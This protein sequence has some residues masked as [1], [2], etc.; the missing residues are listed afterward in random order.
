[1]SSV[2]DELLC[3]VQAAGIHIEVDPPD[4]IVTPEDLLTPELEERLRQH[5]SEILRRLELE[6]SRNRLESAGICVAVWDDGSMRVVV[7]E[8]ETVQ[9]IDA[10]GTVYS[11]AD[12]WHYVQLEPHERRMLY[13]FKKRFGGIVSWEQ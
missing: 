1:M 9:A 8:S 7:T 4:L 12:M 10:G 2:I 13:S 6:A 11:P 3:Q 5:K